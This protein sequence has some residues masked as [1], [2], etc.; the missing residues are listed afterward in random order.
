MDQV[1]SVHDPMYLNNYQFFF[2]YCIAPVVEINRI[3]KSCQYINKLNTQYT[4]YLFIYHDNG[5]Y[6]QIDFYFKT[7]LFL[8]KLFV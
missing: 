7:F 1:Y 6:T 2:G 5:L 8:L 3:Y 4:R